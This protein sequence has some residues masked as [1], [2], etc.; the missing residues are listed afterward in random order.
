MIAE[1]NLSAY[2]ED[3]GI[4]HT[5]LSRKTGIGRCVVDNILGCRREAKADEFILL[6]LALRKDP[7]E[8]FPVPEKKDETNA[9]GNTD[10]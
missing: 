10:V 1:R 7:L 6:C 8:F 4:R 3:E 9:M 5:V 2:V